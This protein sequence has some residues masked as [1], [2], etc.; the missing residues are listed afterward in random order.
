[1]D[2]GVFQNWP[3]WIG[4]CIL[5]Y[6]Y[7]Y[8]GICMWPH[9]QH[10]THTVAS[11][12]LLF[13][14]ERREGDEMDAR[15][16][17]FHFWENIKKKSTHT[18]MKNSKPKT[19]RYSNKIHIYTCTVR[20]NREKGEEERKKRALLISECAESQ[21]K[22]NELNVRSI[23]AYTKYN[24]PHIVHVSGESLLHTWWYVTSYM[25]VHVCVCVWKC[26]W[27]LLWCQAMSVSKI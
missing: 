20:I 17:V 14:R 19:R 9:V 13:M 11:A 25:F 12:W 22:W 24:I 3:D 1:M 27:T 16:K 26:G 2:S 6:V 18:K 21:W 8:I 4:L 23:H 10:T 5:L 15:D 7:V